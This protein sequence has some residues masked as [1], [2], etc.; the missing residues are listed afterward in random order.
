[1]KDK[2]ERKIEYHRMTF[3]LSV[4]GFIG[5]MA[6]YF[7]VLRQVYSA[8]TSEVQ[9]QKVEQLKEENNK[10]KQALRILIEEANEDE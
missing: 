4:I 2:K 5:S 10:L 1:M 8:D 9:K 6:F 3:I 7:G